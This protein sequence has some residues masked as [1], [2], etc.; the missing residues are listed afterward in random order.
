MTA[1]A[2]NAEATT[3]SAPER[4]PLR[5]SYA[6]WLTWEHEGGLTEWVD[7]EVIVL[8]PPTILHQRIVGFLSTL[9][10]LFTQ[11]YHLGQVLAAPVGMRAIVGGNGR[12]PD[13]LFLATENLGFLTERAVEGP[14]DLVVEVISEDSVARDRGDK[15]YE[16][17]EGGVRE[18]WIIDPR[19]S[20]QRVD[21]YVID[22]DARYQPVPV[23][24]D[25]AYH[26]AVLPGFYLKEGWL[27][28]DEPN[29]LAALVELVGLERMMEALRAST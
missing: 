12:E 27:W 9:L 22:R 7:G 11:M 23:A 16:Y 10:H 28:A 13:V 2:P 3:T 18:Y 21:L 8:T 29:P 6:E 17:Q 20:K 4:M 19:P 26:S 15:F 24:S 5:M 1:I 14:A 25:G